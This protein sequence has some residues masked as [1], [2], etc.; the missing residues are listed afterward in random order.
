MLVIRSTPCSGQ[1]PLSSRSQSG[2]YTAIMVL[3]WPRRPGLDLSLG[4]ESERLGT[5]VS[6]PRCWSRRQ[7]R[8]RFTKYLT[9]YHKIIA[10][11]S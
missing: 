10:S 9:I 11:L 6:R 2:L 7:S 1:R 8:S 5:A 4:V 3:Q